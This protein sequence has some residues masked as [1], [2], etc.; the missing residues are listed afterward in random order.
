MWPWREAK[1]EE[2]ILMLDVRGGDVKSGWILYPWKDDGNEFAKYPFRRLTQ[3][4]GVFDL[5]SMENK[6]MQSHCLLPPGRALP[7]P[8]LDCPFGVG[9]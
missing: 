3:H 4:T 7:M 8:V 1:G 9:K 6:E 2:S 5:K